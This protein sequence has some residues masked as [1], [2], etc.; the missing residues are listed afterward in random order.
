[1]ETMQ[2]GEV[3]RAP[4]DVAAAVESSGQI[5]VERRGGGAAFVIS[6]EDRVRQVE[7]AMG[8]VAR[9]IRNL[10]SHDQLDKLEALLVDALPWSRFLPAKD[11]Q[12]FAREIAWTIE[13]CT[14]P[15]MWPPLGRMLHDWRQTAAVH[16]DPALAKELYQALDTDLGPVMMPMPEN[17]DPPPLPGSLR[18]P[19]QPRPRRH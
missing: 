6:R 19:C 9:L 7:G 17:R 15:D 10:V 4:R 8:A 11:R 2:W 13:I 14:D 5:R 1:M 18:W 16:A 12:E 3:A